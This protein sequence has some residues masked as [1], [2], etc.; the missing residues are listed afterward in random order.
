M[1]FTRPYLLYN[2]CILRYRIIEGHMEWKV[3][4]SSVSELEGILVQEV[5]HVAGIPAQLLNQKDSM[6][7]ILGEVRILV[8]ADMEE[9]ARQLLTMQGYLNDRRFLN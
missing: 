3:I 5:L 2:F 6:Y 8:P 7:V 1:R 4:W 9:S